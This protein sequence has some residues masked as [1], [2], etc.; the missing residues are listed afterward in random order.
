PERDCPEVLVSAGMAPR[1][2]TI[3]LLALVTSLGLTALASGA[4]LRTARPS[5][6]TTAPSVPKME[7]TPAYVLADCRRSPRLTLACPRLL[8]RME[9]PS[10]HWAATLCVVRA[11]GCR[12]LTWD[13]LNL[14]DAGA[15]VRP[16]V[17]S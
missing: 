5:R 8:P 6:A 3:G 7:R 12:G 1:A 10:P 17:W 4:H 11:A 13:D 2:L 16:P 15:G 9:P 14:V